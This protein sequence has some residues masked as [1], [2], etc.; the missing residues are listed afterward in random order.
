MEKD[1]FINAV[2]MVQAEGSA[3][4]PTVLYYDRAHHVFIGS[5][6]LAEG[7]PEDLSEDFKIDLGNIDPESKKPRTP[8]FTASGIPTSASDLTA[9]FLN[10]WIKVMLTW[11]DQ[12]T[13]TGSP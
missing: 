11:L 13:F 12:A 5:A 10:S 6:A 2:Q 1:F 7:N 9:D 4:I 3:N 8:F